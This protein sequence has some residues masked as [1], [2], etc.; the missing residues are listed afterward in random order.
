LAAAA[1]CAPRQAEEADKSKQP[2]RIEAAQSRITDDF[3]TI[4]TGTRIDT[5]VT[6]D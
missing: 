3:M 5:T 2:K 4:A 6:E 1:V